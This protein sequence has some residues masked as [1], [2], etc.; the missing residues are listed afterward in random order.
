MR[1]DL[2]THRYSLALLLLTVGTIFGM[3]SHAQQ[4]EISL[5]NLGSPATSTISIAEEEALGEAWLRSF[6]NRTPLMRDYLLQDYVENLIQSL[7]PYSNIPYRKLDILLI[8][9]PT[10][11]AFAVPGGVIGVHNGLL[12]YAETEDEVASVLAHELAHLS[13][14]HFS[15]SQA[16]RQSTG[17]ATMAG[18]L[19]S[20][21]LAAT[22]GGDA[23]MAAMS[24]TQGLAI[25]RELRYSRQN[26]QEADR[27]G[28]AVLFQ[29]G[30]NPEATATM[31][32]HMQDLTRISGSRVP[33]Y[34]LT[35]P[36]PSSRLSDAKS[37]AAQYPQRFYAT[38]LS[39]QLLRTRVQVEDARRAEDALIT[40]N[41]RL[42]REP[43]NIIA[44]YGVALAH[45]RA[46]QFDLADSLI[47]ELRQ[48]EPAQLAF[49]ALE[50]D[51]KIDRAQYDE[52]IALAQRA[53][54]ARPNNHTL[55]MQLS[56]A[57]TRA[58]RYE[59]AAQ[60]LAAQSR[61]RPHDPTLWYDLAETRGLAG[62]ILGLHKARSEYF[63]L[64][65]NFDR[66]IQHFRL[67][68]GL[69]ENNPIET[70]V[71]EERIRQTQKMRERAAF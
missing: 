18:M 50:L 36:L 24:V 29:A 26:E 5:P 65:G 32:E 1:N 37:R 45:R 8:D 47:A 44:K 58:N 17:V 63:I 46:A 57:L 28:Q 60:I 61:N 49:I 2:P 52:A 16:E 13:Q 59:E 51:M 40:F 41:R 68:I 15:R 7:R 42:E 55:T 20:V 11:N 9:N 48:R 4:S 67:A 35:H 30:L 66:A 3:S 56:F 19:A 21:V 6:R 64:T 10:I 62:D 25:D 54:Q 53:L 14:R 43:D 38:N 39:Y 12:N 33:E 27:I 69:L 34:L 23:G 31:F 71:L 22:L 70:A